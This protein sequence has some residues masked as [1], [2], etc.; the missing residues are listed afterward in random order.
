MN[1]FKFFQKEEN[2]IPTITITAVSGTLTTA[3]DGVINTSN[4]F[5]GAL[6]HIHNTLSQ[7]DER[8]NQL[9]EMIRTSQNETI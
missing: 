2:G 7:I 5:N 4:R 9:N 3:G 6:D 8:L 1:E